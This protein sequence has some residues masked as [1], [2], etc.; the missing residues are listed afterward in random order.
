MIVSVKIA[1]SERWCD[2]KH[3]G[4]RR[5]V[6]LTIEIDTA[7]MASPGAMQGVTCGG[8]I[9]KLTPESA[10]NMANVIELELDDADNWW[11]C[12]HVLE[13]D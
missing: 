6:G 3:H 9:W 5:V 10:R 7:T 2:P 1:P 11:A 13:M 8:R 12:E 4:D